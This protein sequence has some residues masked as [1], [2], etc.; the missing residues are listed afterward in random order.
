MTSQSLE[1]L[2]LQYFLPA[3]LTSRYSALQYLAVSLG[4]WL[5]PCTVSMDQLHLSGGL[6]EHACQ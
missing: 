5:V 2:N 6:G 1:K 4:Y 3:G